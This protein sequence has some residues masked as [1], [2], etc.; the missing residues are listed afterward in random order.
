[1]SEILCK[2]CNKWVDCSSDKNKDLGFC[3]NEDLFTYTA[4]DKCSDYSVGKTITEQEYEQSNE[5]WLCK[6]R[7]M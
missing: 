1:M 4:K 6:C 5:E 2:K 7:N 3:L